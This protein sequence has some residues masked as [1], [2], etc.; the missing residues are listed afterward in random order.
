V[1][2][3]RDLLEEW[4]KIETDEELSAWLASL[5]D[6]NR[7]ELREGFREVK[8]EILE[9]L[10]AFQEFFDLVQENAGGGGG[11]GKSRKHEEIT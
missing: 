7:I 2:A 5:S 1:L 4:K 9:I 10:K 6:E 8:R 11:G 3:G